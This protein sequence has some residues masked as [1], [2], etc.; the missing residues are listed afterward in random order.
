LLQTNIISCSVFAAI[1]GSSPVTAAAIGS[2][3]YPEMK[4]KGYDEGMIIGSLAGGGALGILIPPSIIMLIY[5]SITSVSVEKLFMAGVIPGIL[6]SIIFMIYIGIRCLKNPSLVGI[7]SDKVPIIEKLKSILGMLPF[8]LM[9]LIVL[10]G[11]Y[12]GITTPTEAA[13]IGALFALIFSFITRGF[14]WDGMKKS[15]K[16]TIKLTTMILFVIIGA[17]V[18]TYF[19]AL[20]GISSGLALW[21][22][23][24]NPSLPVFLFIITVF[25]LVLGCL[26]DGTSMIFLTIPLLLPILTSL[27]MDLV[28]FGV[29]LTILIEIAQITPP[30]GMNLYVLHGIAGHG[31]TFGKVCKSVLPYLFMYLA[32]AVAIMIFPQIAVWFPYSMGR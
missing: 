9:I 12:F 31:I 7:K 28:W 3:A 5:G 15:L 14:T 17:K 27:N 29:I 21:I 11:I 16:S 4:K 25:Y 23:E 18:L 30:V 10:G 8:L 6:M 13:A 19:V 24:I 32:L 2:V 20:S 1:C 22:T 26:I